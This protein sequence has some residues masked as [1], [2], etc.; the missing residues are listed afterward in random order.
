MPPIFT[1]NKAFRPARLK[2]LLKVLI[3]FTIQQAAGCAKNVEEILDLWRY[4]LSL[5]AN[6][7]G[8]LV[9]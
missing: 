5:F 8:V 3:I 7:N 6:P 4:P 2:V 9:F 1:I